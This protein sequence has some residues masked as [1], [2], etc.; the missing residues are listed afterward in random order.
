MDEDITLTIKGDIGRMY[1]LHNRHIRILSL[2]QLSA[3]VPDS[4]SFNEFNKSQSII[5]LA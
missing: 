1:S 4:I 3:K 2:Y 5:F